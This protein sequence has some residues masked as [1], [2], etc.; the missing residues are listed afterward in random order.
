LPPSSEKEKP[1]ESKAVERLQ[2]SMQ[3]QFA[4]FNEMMKELAAG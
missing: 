1:L 4:L 2:E 3:T